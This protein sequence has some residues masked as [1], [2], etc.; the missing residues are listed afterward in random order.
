[1]T[2]LILIDIYILNLRSDK[3]MKISQISTL[4][5]LRQ[6]TRYKI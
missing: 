6:N 4:F 2:L 1:M 3:I 5:I